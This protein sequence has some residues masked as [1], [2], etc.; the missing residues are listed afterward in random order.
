[1]PSHIHLLLAIN[2]AVLSDFMRDF[3]KYIS[4]KEAK[5]LG[6]LEKNIWQYR[7]DRVAINSEDVLKTKLDYIHNNPLRAK[8]VKDAGDWRW[9]SA[10]DYYKG[11]SG[12]V[13]VW[14]DWG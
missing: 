11:V 2:G 10:G 7:Y 4:Q 3:K 9:S 6:I 12:D 1:M 13:P 5:S 14:K 8:I